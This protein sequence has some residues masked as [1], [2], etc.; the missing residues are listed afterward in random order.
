MLG[1]LPS[2]Q[3]QGQNQ[4]NSLAQSQSKSINDALAAA[5]QT[6]SNNQTVVQGNEGQAM[7]DLNDQYSHAMQAMNNRLGAQGAANSSAADQWAAW[8]SQQAN[9]D[10]GG[11]QNQ[12]N[13]QYNDIANT[14]VNTQSAAS[15]QL[16]AV[17]T[18]A[19]S[20]TTQ[21]TN[22]YND[23]Q[24]Q[25]EQQKNSA[26]DQEKQA[27][28]QMQTQVYQAAQN[29]LYNIQAYQ[30]QA[31]AYMAQ[32][33][34]TQSAQLGNYTQAVGSPV[35]NL[36]LPQIQVGS[37]INI[38]NVGNLTNNGDGI[39]TLAGG[40]PMS[41]SQMSAQLNNMNYNTASLSQLAQNQNLTTQ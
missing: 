29:Q 24:R 11:L 10:R 14:K 34:G 16:D 26:S 6:L 38:P 23:L 13:T 18:W 9:K 41:E 15:Q 17:Q 28:A 2:Q 12:Y 31:Q 40:T 7:N 8:Y 37:S 36:S 22:T 30:A 4:I 21:L 25:L 32:A 5:L 27:I 33:M 19:N 20:Q 39:W 3:Q 35:S 1:Q